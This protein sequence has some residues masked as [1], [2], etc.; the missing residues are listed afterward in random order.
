MFGYLDGI[1]LLLA[2][3]FVLV[4]IKR[5]FLGSLAK[6]LG[7]FVRLI[8][9]ILLAK[10]FVKLISLT[11]IDE[12]LFDKLTLKYS[13][14]SDKFNVN[15]VGMDSASLDT[16][17]TD[18]LSDAKVPKIFRS[19][20]KNFIMVNPDVIAQKETV[21]VAELAGV[22]VGNLILLIVSFVVIYLLLWLI[23]KIVLRVSTSLNRSQTIIGGTNRWLGGVFG[24]VKYFVFLMVAML[25]V[26]ALS[27]FDFMGNTVAY[28]NNSFLGGPLYRLSEKLWATSFD[29]TSAVESWLKKN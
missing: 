13:G 17:V 3:V 14:I 16:F 11:K 22:A 12:H 15:L 20:V 27:K 18:A 9:S 5:G 2:L 26:S 29:I 25:V 6:L 7:G 4:G 21:T 1:I 8:L 24:F 10:P 28:I 19:L 23:V